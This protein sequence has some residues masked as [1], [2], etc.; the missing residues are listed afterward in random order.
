V[1][2]PGIEKDSGPSATLGMTQLE[3]TCDVSRMRSPRATRGDELFGLILPSFACYEYVMD[4]H[5]PHSFDPPAELLT[6][7]ANICHAKSSFDGT[8][9]PVVV[10]EPKTTIMVWLSFFHRI[11]TTENRAIRQRVNSKKR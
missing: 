11:P 4:N 6:H 2:K 7:R 9:L 3:S 1:N 8:K 10:G 5:A